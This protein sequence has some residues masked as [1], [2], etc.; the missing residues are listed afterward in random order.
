MEK[1]NAFYFTGTGNTRYVTL[2][3]CKKLSSHYQTSAYDISAASDFTSLLENVD[4]ILLA[5]PIYG[6]SPPVPMRRFVY[7]YAQAFKNKEVIIVITQYFFSGDGAASLGRTVE[8]FGGK[9]TFAEHFNMP[10]NLSDCKIFAVKNGAELEGV[11]QKAE[12][13][14][15]RFAERIIN[16]KPFRRGF[17]PLSHAVGY[18]SQRKFFRRGEE[19]KKTKLHIDSVKCIGCG[20]CEKQCPVKN[21]RVEQG[22]AVPQGNC[23]LCYRCVN[24]CPKKAITLCGKQPPEI[25][26]KGISPEK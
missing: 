12:K 8:K 21:I 1:L 4:C 25:Q 2:R 7:K 22:K 6:S 17:N 20:L 23:A 14:M 13:R 24:L 5:F 19:I 9:V 26:Y 3:L 18:Y 15:E 11:L 16:G 10:N